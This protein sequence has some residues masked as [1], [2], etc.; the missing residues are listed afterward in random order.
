MV[1][2]FARASISTVRIGLGLTWL[3]LVALGAFTEEGAF[4]LGAGG[5]RP[6]GLGAGAPGPGTSLSEPCEIGQCVRQAS[7]TKANGLGT[8]TRNRDA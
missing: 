4:A 6:G 7:T 1:D 5:C 2:A 8:T 3:A